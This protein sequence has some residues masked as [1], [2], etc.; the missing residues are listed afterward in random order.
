[1]YV[2][3]R[4]ILPCIIAFFLLLTCWSFS[5]PI[6]SGV[7]T[8]YHLASIWCAWGEKDGLCENVNSIT[9]TGEV[10]FMF[11]FCN[12]RNADYWPY[13]ENPSVQ[14]DKQL[15]IYAGE[16]KMSFYYKIMHVF[17]S[18]DVNRSVLMIRLVNSLLAVIVTFLLLTITNFRIR[19]AGLAGL[20]FSITPLAIQYFAGI[21]PRGWAVLGVV[22]SWAFLSSYIRTPKD[23]K[24]IRRLELASFVFTAAL[25]LFTRIDAAVM[26][27][28]TS[29]FVFIGFRF[30]ETALAKQNLLILAFFV[31]AISALLAFSSRISALFSID[32]PPD[33][34][35]FQYIVF[36]IV[37]I[38]EFVADWW[39]YHV[40]QQGNGPG[41][42]GILGL[43]LFAVALA[44]SM[45]NSDIRQ[46]VMVGA[47]TLVIFALL[48]KSTLATGSL[49]PLNGAYTLGMASPWLGISIAFSRTKLQFMS[50]F[51]NRRVVIALLSFAH[52]ISFYSWMEFYTKRGKGLGFYQQ[53]SLDGTW[54][55]DTWISPNFVFL[56]GA[57]LFPVFLTYAWKSIPLALQE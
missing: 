26:V 55:W 2:M 45:Q 25:A 8:E 28:I 6:G 42:V 4:Q 34:G 21:N 35:R 33:V 18:E 44:F 16:P 10:P 30:K 52:A 5:S 22:T 36:S 48:M 12:G 3:R 41:L 13:C 37:H 53:L 40:G 57:L 51:G 49:I 50:S 9:S 47:F 54:W 38:P 19:N 29:L 1:M 56:F 43:T 39:G 7:D 17:A 24:L 11:H 27:M 46:R 20:T 15:L 14:P 31:G 32:I 23:Q